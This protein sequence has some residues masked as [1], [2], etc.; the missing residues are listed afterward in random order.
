VVKRVENA[1]GKGT[2]SVHEVEADPRRGKR[3]VYVAWYSAGMRVLA[4]DRAG[5]LRQ[6]GRFIARAGNDFWGVAVQGRGTRRPLIYGSDRDF[7][8]WIFRYTGRE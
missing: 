2:M 5:N 6:V 8:L 1:Y 4:Y 3:L 7:G